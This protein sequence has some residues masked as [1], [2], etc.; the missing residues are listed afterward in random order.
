MNRLVLAASLTSCLFATRAAAQFTD[1]RCANVASADFR[2]A[3]LFNKNG[4]GAGVADGSLTE[5]VQF[6][7]HAVRNAQGALTAVDIYFVQRLGVVKRY[8]GAAKKVAALG[9][10]PNWGKVDNGLMGL[11]LHP[12][13]ARNRWI[14]FWYS[15]NQLVGQNRKLRLTRITMKAD[16][17]LDMGS[18]KI[19]IE[20]LASKTDSYH[21]GGPMAFDRH[22]DLWITIGNNSPDLE[23][24]TLNVLST[25]DSTQSAEW[26]PSN[27]ASMRGGIIRIHPDSTS[28]GYAI[29]KGN[30]GEYWADEF[31]KQGKAALADQYRNPAKVLPEVYVKGNRSNYSIAL[32]P[33]KDWL[34]WGEVN[35]AGTNDEYNLV[36]RPSF[37]GF[38]YFHANN[39]PTGAH[40]KSAA[41]PVNNSPFNSGVNELPPAVPGLINNLIN[42]AITG[43]IYVFDSTL[44]SEVKFPP[45]MSQTWITMSWSA[46][47]MHIHNLEAA[48]PG[49]QKTTRADNGLL[50]A[51]KLRNPLQAKYGPEGALYVLNYDGSYSAINPGLTRVEYIGS[52]KV[53]VKTIRVAA[54]PE[55]DLEI[56]LAGG[57]LRIGGSGRHEF[58]VH[59]LDGRLLGTWSGE[60]RAAYSLPVLAG[61]RG[62]RKGIYLL[63]VKTPEG[64]LVRNL[65]LL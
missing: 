14:Y 11:A 36:S 26:G 64:S 42:V 2:A 25:T 61:E 52:C 43:P 41:A 1:P 10:I 58:S 39:A 65:S 40:G 13:F 7:L 32:H 22:G 5:P 57:N 63:R 24:N 54:L 29:P 50:S 20:I 53:P 15:P 44:D 49:V 23:P 31:A 37:V 45:H 16:Y 9:T 48:Q 46:S 18:E 28:K 35:Y 59:G 27:T 56:V 4:A 38:P 12:D 55:A 19:L 62:L 21:S 8:D 47:Q 34:A 51:L 33:T 6:D 17:T 60:G 3:E 30:F